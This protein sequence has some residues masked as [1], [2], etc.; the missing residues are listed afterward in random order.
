[1]KLT[2]LISI[3][4]SACLLQLL[5]E[6]APLE[7][8]AVAPNHG[9]LGQTDYLLC[10]MVEGPQIPY[11]QRGTT[12]CA[13]CHPGTLPAPHCK[14]SASDPLSSPRHGSVSRTCSAGQA[15]GERQRDPI[16]KTGEEG[17]GSV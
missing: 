5:G 1:M 15:A 17:L 12:L 3:S 8:S 16:T 13:S 10:S 11:G 9:P 6:G 14:S 7:G 2:F 4:P